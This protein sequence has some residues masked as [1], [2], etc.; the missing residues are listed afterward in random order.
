MLCVCY[1]QFLKSECNPCECERYSQNWIEEVFL[2]T[3]GTL[4]VWPSFPIE[5]TFV[6]LLDF[7]VLHVPSSP[8]VPAHS[9][10]SPSIGI[11]HTASPFSLS[12]SLCLLQ[13]PYHY[14][15]LSGWKTRPQ[16]KTV[17][18]SIK[19]S[20]QIKS[21]PLSGYF[22]AHTTTPLSESLS[23]PPPPPSP[24]SLSLSLVTSEPI[25]LLYSLSPCLSPP[26]HLSLSLSLWLL[27]SPYH[28]ST[29][30]LPVS[31]SPFLSFSFLSLDTS[32]PIPLLHSLSLPPSLS[33]SP[34]L[35]LWLLQSLYYYSTVPL[36][37]S[38]VT[39]EPFLECW[40]AVLPM[41]SI[42]HTSRAMLIF[43]IYSL[44]DSWINEAEN[45]W[46]RTEK[47][48]KL[49]CTKQLYTISEWGMM[50]RAWNPPCHQSRGRPP[51]ASV[52]TRT[53]MTPTPMNRRESC[54]P[55][56]PPQLKL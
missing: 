21:P 55:M 23:L 30:S 35:S 44:L 18:L 19:K 40:T 26:P 49:T 4:W 3:R 32:E 10:A 52:T 20:N 5:C 46:K 16:P 51:V 13:S 34:P 43:I 41:I 11:Y 45:C 22:R 15:T 36:S 29:L 2:K 12:L 27:Q 38:L 7:W 9:S 14:S 25:P 31:L 37:L 6:H 28:Y 33:L 56:V 1:T 8:S 17:I 42:W 24:S 54:S 53:A 39:S 48:V 47:D 50:L